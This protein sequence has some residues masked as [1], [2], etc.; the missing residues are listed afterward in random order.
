MSEYESGATLMS[1]RHFSLLKSNNSKTTRSH[2]GAMIRPLSLTSLFN[3]RLVF[4]LL[5][6]LMLAPTAYAQFDTATVLGTVTDTSGAAVQEPPWTLKNLAT[7]ITAM[8]QTGR[9]R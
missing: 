8:A 7:G 6:V 5:A 9:G 2:G 3:F 4:S 1:R